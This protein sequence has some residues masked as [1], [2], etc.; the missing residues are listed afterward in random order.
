MPLIPSPIEVSGLPQMPVHALSPIHSPHPSSPDPNHEEPADLS[1]SASY[2][3]LTTLSK[4]GPAQIKRTFSENVLSMHNRTEKVSDGVQN[5]NKELFRRASKKAKKRMSLSQAK[6]SLAHDDDDT[7]TNGDSHEYR[8]SRSMTGTFR[9][10]A[11]KSWMGSRSS[12]PVDDDKKLDRKQSWSPAKKAGRLAADRI[13]VPQR[14]V[15]RSPSADSRD[16]ERE[17]RTA[18]PPVLDTKSAKAPRKSDISPPKRPSARSSISSFRS[19][20]SSDK[21]K[22]NSSRPPMP[23]SLSSDQ[24]SAL[25]KS[26]KRDPLWHA[27]RQIEGELSSFQGKTSMQKSKV[28]RAVLLPF[29]QDNQQHPASL[30]LRPED[31]DR[32]VTI[33]NKWWCVLLEILAGHHNQILSGSDRPAFLEAAA[34][35]M[36]RP[37]WRIPGFPTS[38]IETQ[39]AT[40]RS[41]GSTTSTESEQL[42]ETI[43][44]NIR[45]IFVQNLLA[46]LGYVIDKLCMRSAP[47]S[48]VNFSGRTCAY[49]FF[50]CPGVAEMLIRLWRLTPG[51]LRR[52][53]VE[54]G[55]ERGEKLE[56]ASKEL[57]ACLPAPMQ[58]LVFTTQASL[59]RMMQLRRHVPV[60]TEHFKWHG[61]WLGRWSGRDSDLF[62]NF[63]KFYHLLLSDYIPEHVSARDRVC[64]PGLAPVLAQVLTVLETT[65]YRQAGQSAV[66]NYASGTAAGMD[67]A[68]SMAPLPMTIANATRQMN[69]NR[70]VMLLRDMLGDPQFGNGQ[71]RRLFVSGY[72]D[73]VKA[74]ARKV[75]LYNND[76]CFVLCDF[77]EEMFP[78]LARH[79]QESLIDWPFW[80]QV[81]KQMMHSQN[82]LTQIRLIAFVYSM[83]NILITNDERKQELIL[84]W[85]LD[86]SVFDTLFCHWSP[87]VR[88]YFFR[89]LC[90]RVARIDH[91]PSEIDQQR[92]RLLSSHLNRVWAYYQY[93]S[94]EADMRDL[95]QPSTVPCSPAP[96]RVLLI[97]RTDTA[98]QGINGSAFSNFDKFLAQGLSTQSNSP[99]QKSSSALTNSVPSPD[100]TLQ[101]GV[102]KRWSMLKNILPFGTPGNDRP[103]EVTPPSTPDDRRSL[104]D[105]SRPPTPPHQAFSFK[106]SL[107]WAD[108]RQQATYNQQHRKLVAPSLPISAEEV[109]RTSIS[110]THETTPSKRKSDVQPRKPSGSSAETARYA[111]RA[112]AE[113]SQ[114]ITEYRNFLVRRRQEGVPKF[115]LVE[116]PTLGVETFRMMG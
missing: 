84:D 86:R 40:Q 60:G 7:K 80:L 88:H 55:I 92:L 111:G 76:A 17:P 66:D 95:V 38:E 83:W 64:T 6:F 5:A 56:T 72:G 35:I 10:L 109:F 97:I 114:V 25:E 34:Q 62:F 19:L 90:W 107:E 79:H 69:E 110:S 1:R 74:A 9:S 106:F 33:L 46:Q 93:L 105:V 28:L 12:S 50:F 16:D 98:G 102:K 51:I 116:T 65:I 23:P 75:S 18:R 63:T 2:T 13:A 39:A 57:A 87:M 32:R 20:A 82:T 48:L 53:F 68:D 27:F 31:L 8:L 24:L 59:A 67:V 81:C 61:P 36:M 104:H 73:V 96:S 3:Y 52:I 78:L 103:G 100:T 37:E 113:W 112:L 91:E 15:S 58:D 47:A 41:N 101:N 94:A 99:Y 43:Y 70:L 26:N 71:V 77:L 4:D 49:A 89:L 11:R 42:L 14:A 44:Q 29:L 45:S 54:A 108:K 115:A 85:L 22:R 30:V 21:Q